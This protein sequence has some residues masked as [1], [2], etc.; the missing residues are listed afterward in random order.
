MTE[1]LLRSWKKIYMINDLEKW[2]MC[3]LEVSTFDYETI[4]AT[5]YKIKELKELEDEK[6]INKRITRKIKQLF[7]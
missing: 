4:M 5:L 1:Y 6:R 3:M 2:L 7:K